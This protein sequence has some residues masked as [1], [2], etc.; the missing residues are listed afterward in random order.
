[1]IRI[2]LVDDNKSLLSSIS[3]MLR[4]SS[5]FD[6]VLCEDSCLHLEDKLSNSLP[7]ILLMDIDMPG[8]NGIEGVKKVKKNFP[9]IIVIMFTAFEDDEKIFNSLMAGASGYL[10]KKSP[11]QKIIEAILDARDGGAPMSPA[12]AHRVITMFT[13][14][15]KSSIE[16]FKLSNREIEILQGLVQGLS[17]K[18]LGEKFHIST[19]TVRSHLKN[20]YEKLH[21]NSKAQAVAKA[22]NEKLV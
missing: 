18:Q 10:L 20:I 16:N 4:E 13:G 9:S 15:R 8:L 12:I 7:Q 21:V 19:D 2:G 17:Y 22:L 14:Q 1:M 3:L 5:L 11:P 6:V